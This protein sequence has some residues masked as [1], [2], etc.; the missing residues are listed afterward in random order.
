M[1][2]LAPTTAL[3]AAT[4][5]PEPCPRVEEVV[6]EDAVLEGEELEQLAKEPHVSE[7]AITSTSRLLKL[8]DDR[9]A[10]KRAIGKAKAKGKSKGKPTAKGS[11]QTLVDKVGKRPCYSVE[12]S[13]NQVL[14]RTGLGGPNSTFKFAYG[15]KHAT[16]KTEAAAIRLAE[17]WVAD[18]LKRQG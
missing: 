14:C 4:P 2:L 1:P 8:I 11:R 9:D 3:L 7:D 16:C 15:P 5:R 18:E 13:R 10:E 6:G 17:K 12:R